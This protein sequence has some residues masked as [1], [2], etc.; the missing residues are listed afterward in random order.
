MVPLVLCGQYM[1]SPEQPLYS[2]GGE[3]LIDGG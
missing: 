1:C 3:C 2:A